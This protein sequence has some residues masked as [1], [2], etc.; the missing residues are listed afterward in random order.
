MKSRQFAKEYL[1]GIAKANPDFT[2]DEVIT[3]YHSGAGNVRKAK[4]GVEALGINGQ[5]YAGKVNAAEVPPVQMAS[6]SNDELVNMYPNAE[7]YGSRTDGVPEEKSYFDTALDYVKG[8]PDAFNKNM[9]YSEQLQ[10][11]LISPE[12]IEQGKRALGY[13]LEIFGVGGVSESA[14]GKAPGNIINKILPDSDADKYKEINDN[15]QI[16][17]KENKIGNAQEELD[18]F[19]KRIAEQIAN[20]IKPN[21]DDLET[22]NELENDLK[23]KKD[24]LDKF[25]KKN[26]EFEKEKINNQSKIDDAFGI[27]SKEVKEKRIADEKKKRE[28]AQNISDQLANEEDIDQTVMNN[29]EVNQYLIDN[30]GKSATDKFIDKAKGVGKVVLDKSMEYFKNAFSS[31]FDGEELARMAMIYAGSR[32]LGYN[33]GGSLNYSMKNYIKR[34]DAN[35]SAAKTFSL[36]DKAREDYSEASL[37]EYSKTGDRDVLIPKV[38][39][40]SVTKPAG[41]IYARGFGELPT[42][43]MSDKTTKVLHRGEYKSPDHPDLKGRVEKL[44]SEVHGD[45]AVANRFATFATNEVPVANAKYGLKENKSKNN[46]SDNRFKVNAKDIGQQANSFYRNV[47]RSNGVSINDAPAFEAA[48]NR[49]IKQYLDEMGN[50]SVN[51]GKAPSLKAYLE[52]QTFVPL[53]GIDQGM[54]SNTS[55]KEL[56][57]IYDQ[58]ANNITY[59]K[60]DPRYQNQLQ[61]EWKSR[62]VAFKWIVDNDKAT[63]DNILKDAMARTEADNGKSWDAFTYW[64]SKTPESK[65][66]EIL[67][68][69]GSS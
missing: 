36:T 44:N 7:N 30:P 49:G 52:E 54:V 53:T 27:E 11:D 38:K 16:G 60:N 56:K 59:K 39:S 51:G 22:K 20:G 65:V 37:K 58:V 13:P 8:I 55:S 2:E 29:A 24:D 34:V 6:L 48:V 42:F 15:Y 43:V 50:V 69:V 35:L 47:L 3:A 46:P 67:D 33:H 26:I 1:I 9:Q 62:E 4:S 64:V 21:A 23:E 31:M 41:S 18:A 45:V 40:L 28:A 19:N 25:N 61:V 68:K 17:L 66:L 32:A 14:P 57:G 10:R 12:S 63:Y 5:E